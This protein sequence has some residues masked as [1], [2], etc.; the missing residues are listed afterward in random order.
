V[1]EE[2]VGERASISSRG[3]WPLRATSPYGSRGEVRASLTRVAPSGS[4]L[5]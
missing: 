3:Q 2:A 1:A 5:L 4:S